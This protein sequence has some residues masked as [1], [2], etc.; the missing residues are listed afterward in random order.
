MKRRI[1]FVDDE[2][3][4]L[5]GLERLLRSMRDEWTL[6]FAESGAAALNILEAES[7]AFDVVVSDMRMPGMDGAQLLEQV[8]HRYPQVVRIILSGH[9][10]RESILRSIGPTH[11]FMA[12]PCDADELRQVVARACALRDLLHN[13]PLRQLVFAVAH[14]SQ[15]AADVR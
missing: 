7:G 14:D 12:K 5:Q 1:L 3:C 15:L 2:P 13:A 10:E 6:D 4:V 9:S 8:K 11:Q